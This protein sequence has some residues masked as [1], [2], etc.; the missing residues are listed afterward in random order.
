MSGVPALRRLS[1]AASVS[2]RL[3]TALGLDRLSPIMRT[4]NWKFWLTV[5]SGYA[6]E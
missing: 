5:A 6:R 2:P 4:P 3:A 1:A